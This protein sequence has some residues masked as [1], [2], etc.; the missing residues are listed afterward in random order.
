MKKEQAIQFAN[1]KAKQAILVLD[2][3]V[4]Q[5]NLAR[6]TKKVRAFLMQAIATEKGADGKAIFNN[7]DKRQTEIAVREG[8]L[9]EHVK[10]LARL[11]AIAWEIQTAQ[12]H[13]DYLRD[14]VAIAVAFA[15]A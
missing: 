4:E 8:A 13:Y 11:D 1:D 2:L 9:S 3:R 14:M 5:A 12:N 7:E 6:E 15:G 10:N